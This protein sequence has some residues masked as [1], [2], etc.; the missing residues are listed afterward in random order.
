MFR[1]CY[2]VLIGYT[3]LMERVPETRKPAFTAV[4]RPYRS[5]GRPGFIIL[6]STIALVSFI[7]GLAFLYLDAWPVFGFFGLDVALVYWAFKRNYADADIFEAIEI[8]GGELTVR[9]GG[10]KQEMQEWRFQTYWVR[11]EL[12]EN[13]SLET[14]GP[15]WLKSHGKRLQ[16]G[17]FLGSG[18][19]RAF[20]GVL[21]EALQHTKR[22]APGN[23]AH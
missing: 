15:L 6:M 5:L 4:L 8:S 16:V 14:C 1:C 12:E 22:V 23:G 7:A 19:L 3:L 17:S 9:K 18:E 11:M 21:A 13:M 20:A 10:V 2:L